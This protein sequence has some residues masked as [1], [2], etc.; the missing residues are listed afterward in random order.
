MVSG[1]ALAQHPGTGPVRCQV[2][3]RGI[4]RERKVYRMSGVVVVIG[5]A[6]LVASILGVIL[7]L[8]LLAA[9]V[10]GFAPTVSTFTETQRQMMV[11]AGVPDSFI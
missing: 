9:P 1:T 10:L 2:C 11:D 6:L 7:S 3:R 5:Y 8:L 4:L